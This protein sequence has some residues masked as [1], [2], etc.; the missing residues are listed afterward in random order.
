MGVSEP[1]DED[2]DSVDDTVSGAFKAFYQEYLRTDFELLTEHYSQRECSINLDWEELSEFSSDLADDY[3]NR[4]EKIKRAAKAAF[5]EYASEVAEDVE[6]AD[7][8]ADYQSGY[9]RF[10]NLPQSEIRELRADNLNEPVTLSGVVSKCT[11]VTPKLTQAKFRC[12]RRFHEQ[13]K[14]I[15]QEGSHSL[16]TPPECH[17]D[18]CPSNSFQVMYDHDDT[19]FIDRQALIL[20]ERPEGLKGG[21]RPQEI[22]VRYEGDITGGLNPGDRVS[23]SGVLRAEQKDENGSVIHDLY[24][25][26]E[27]FHHEETD[28]EDVDY[29][30][31][32]D[33]IVEMVNG[34]DEPLTAVR[35]S[36][37]PSIHGYEVQKDAIALQLFGGATKDLPDGSSVRGDVHILLIGDPG[38]GKSQILQYV[39]EIAPRSVYSSGKGSSAAGLTAAAVRDDFGD[40]NEWTLEAG[41]LVLA[42]KGLAAIDELDKMRPEDRSSMH[43]ALEQ[44]EIS[45]AK[46]GINATLKSRCS[47]LG[48]ANPKYGRFDEYEPV[49]QQIDLE[50]ALISRFDLIFTITDNPD[51]ESDGKLADHILSSNQ[52]GQVQSGLEKGEKLPDQY[53]E[54]VEEIEP[55]I[56]PDMLRKYIA[57]A[58]NEINPAMD[59]DTKAVIKEFYT[60]LR[61]EDE[62]EG[63]DQ[64]P[65]AIT[66]RQLEAC[67]RLAEA[68]ARIRLSDEVTAQ[69]AEKAVEILMKS[70]E[71]VGYDPETGDLDVDMIATGTSTSGRNKIRSIAST[72]EDLLEE[73][74][75]DG[76]V[77]IEDI[78]E[79]IGESEREVEETVEKLKRKGEIYN[80]KEGGYKPL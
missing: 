70:L 38:T 4:P 68:H 30:G 40:G 72:I 42:D 76:G 55:V 59:E 79:E 2:E 11:D 77:P 15:L 60:N 19:E 49:G 44:Q 61:N 64:S 33:E 67:V 28:F 32:E 41:A 66:P 21:E 62:E 54:Q 25:D 7:P 48:A 26:G 50:P 46:A 71:D 35:Q 73:N 13:P 36:I 63:D 58:K 56:E 8:D 23:V 74:D 10:H 1:T 37:A 34:F 3:R 12:T 45:V 22:E 80:P 69:D 5:V 65:V 47:L 51:E 14:H 53:S 17:R 78:A 16:R 57:Y 39:G 18:D 27:N 52:V 31:E 6:G 24:I 29:E 75:Y 9:V 20:Q 43:Q